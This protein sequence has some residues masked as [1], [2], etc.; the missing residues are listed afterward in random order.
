MDLTHVKMEEEILPWAYTCL[1]NWQKPTPSVGEMVDYMEIHI[2]EKLQSVPHVKMSN[3][4]K[5]TQV[6]N[7]QFGYVWPD[8]TS[9]VNDTLPPV[10]IFSVFHGTPEANSQGFAQN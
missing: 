5:C 9:L 7:R 2:N 4:V 6:L 10:S 3:R 8:R 1:T